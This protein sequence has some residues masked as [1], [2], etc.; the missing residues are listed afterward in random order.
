M[1]K[2]DRVNIHQTRLPFSV[3]FSHSLRT[4]TSAKNIIVEVLADGGYITGYGEGA[5]RSYV[6]GESQRSAAEFAGRLIGEDVFPWSLK[7]VAQIWEFIDGLSYGKEN[8]AA[9]C[10]VETALLDAMGKWQGKSVVEYFPADNLAATV[11]Y[12]AVVP[13][14]HRQRIV[15]ICELVKSL[16][17]NKVRLKMGID[18]QQNKEAMEAVQSVFKDGCDLRVD[19]NGA[20]DRELSLRHAPLIRTYPVKVVEQPMRPGN[21]DIADFAHAMQ[22]AEV[23]LMADESIC[24]LQ[25]AQR[26]FSEGHYK[27]VNVRLSKCGGFRRSLQIIEHCRNTGFLYQ[28]GCH[29]GES[30]I[31]SAAGRVLSLLCGD[32]LYHDGSYDE[33]LLKDNVTQSNVSFGLKG[34]AGPLNGP[35][36]GVEVNGENLRRLSNGPPL[37]IRRP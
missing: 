1:M 13:L 32:A 2:I 28:I 24:S 10:A 25:D 3:E 5:P 30:G 35:G 37:T 8:N 23:I 6:T 18:F 15:Q 31:L 29:L 22:A 33:F 19:I 7:E 20:W 21:P 27:M 11:H 16:Q 26:I 4:K 14:S 9:I 17:I 34:L 12:G 36:Y